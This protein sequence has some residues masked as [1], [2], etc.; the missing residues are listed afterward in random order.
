MTAMHTKPHSASSSPGS[1]LAALLRSKWACL[2][3]LAGILATLS[4]AS[5]A[6]EFHTVLG[7]GVGA[8]AGAAI[9]QSVGGHNGALVGAGAGGL[10]GASVARGHATPAYPMYPAYPVHQTHVY[11]PPPPV[12]AWQPPVQ[13][14]Q[15]SRHH[16][17]HHGHHYAHRENHRDQHYAPPVRDSGRGYQRHWD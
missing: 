15:P 9:G 10:I 1:P 14:W 17:H 3:L 8:A 11:A 7:A 6:N 16:H 13:H 4:A 2:A 5:R 12:V